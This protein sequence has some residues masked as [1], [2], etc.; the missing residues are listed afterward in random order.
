MFVDFGSLVAI[1]NAVEIRYTDVL[2]LL[3]EGAF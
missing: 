3:D 1:N 2:L